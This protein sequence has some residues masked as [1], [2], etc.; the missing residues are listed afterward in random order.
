MKI[1][2]RTAKG[3]CG[4]AIAAIVF[5]GAAFGAGA[6]GS[7]KSGANTAHAEGV[8][9]QIVFDGF[10]DETLDANEWENASE[11][12]LLNKQY[13]ALRF[14]NL[15]QWGAHVL[16]NGYKI[17]V[18]PENADQKTGE[19]AKTEISFI[20][21]NAE[22]VA[23]SWLGV[24]F[25][26]ISLHSDFDKNANYLLKFGSGDTTFTDSVVQGVG[27]EKGR[28]TPI[29]TAR[30]AGKEV[31]VKATLEKYGA[32]DRGESLYDI[33][34]K[35]CEL[36][37]N[38]EEGAY[39]TDIKKTN[40]ANLRLDGYLSFC[41][42]DGMSVDMRDFSITVD[43]GDGAKQAAK[44]DF[45]SGTIGYSGSDGEKWTAYIFNAS[46]V[47]IGKINTVRLDAQKTLISKSRITHNGVTEKQFVLSF[48]CYAENAAAGEFIGVYFDYKGKKYFIGA[49]EGVSGENIVILMQGGNTLNA[50][51]S[52][53]VLF[54]SS[55]K[56]E[57][58]LAGDFAYGVTLSVNGKEF[59]FSNVAFGGV[60][61]IGTVNLRSVSSEA[62]YEIDN[63]N[64]TKYVYKVSSAPSFSTNFGGKK[65]V[66][67]D[68]FTFYEHYFN[69]SRY[70]IGSEVSVPKYSE[71]KEWQYLR[72]LSKSASTKSSC[73]FAPKEKYGEYILRFDL[74][75]M[76]E[77]V[78][79]ENA[80]FNEEG[81]IAS[82]GTDY[83][84]KIGLSFGKQYLTQDVKET[85]GIYFF[86]HYSTAKADGENE[87]YHE[88]LFAVMDTN[89]EYIFESCPYDIFANTDKTYN[90]MIIVRNS[91]L[92][93]YMKESGETDE[94]FD[95]P[96]CVLK[97]VNGYGHPV[98]TGLDYAE[99]RLYSYSIINISPAEGN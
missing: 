65:A 46:S 72:F 22:G 85:G 67:S 28:T 73:Y 83:N 91:E 98:I 59:T 33:E 70:T 86:N 17:G 88:T 49:G 15:S 29:E 34:V 93:L 35:H 87:F 74:R 80:V 63:V 4:A 79:K 12:G 56:N 52:S 42:M 8:K 9:E 30:K 5:C 99:F 47:S 95:E 78:Q 14:T 39:V 37:E 43:N 55:G 16:F 96:V 53:G 48:D 84:A 64:Y 24:T 81:K 76:N 97:G 32:N 18:N 40:G 3:L 66:E 25:G 1:K 61:A 54:K 19:T 90:V 21:R 45:S 71:N 38:G 51:K 11:E 36:A 82:R 60:W 31:L 41:G 89:G 68:G 94:K 20:L 23:K 57:I 75:V 69:Y 44:D 6:F 62:W 50:Q 58:S 27:V 10:D 77:Y 92:R 13:E 2:K 7:R 26:N